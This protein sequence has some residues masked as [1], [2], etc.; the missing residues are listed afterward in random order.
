MFAFLP[1]SFVI[2]VI[3]ENYDIILPYYN[4]LHIKM[5]PLVKAVFILFLRHEEGIVFKCL[6]DYRDELKDIHL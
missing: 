4:D 5:E 1:K 3:T 6:S 2:S